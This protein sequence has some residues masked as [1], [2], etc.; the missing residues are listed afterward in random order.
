[1][2]QNNYRYYKIGLT[3][4]NKE[5]ELASKV[6]RTSIQWCVPAWD[7]RTCVDQ[8]GQPRMGAAQHRVVAVIWAGY[9]FERT[10]GGRGIE[11]GAG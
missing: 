8:G 5:E 6:R 9:L 4:L 10:T 2:R 3:C 1:M 11:A 7:V